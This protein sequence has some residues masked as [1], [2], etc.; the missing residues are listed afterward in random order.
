MPAA[1]TRMFVRSFVR[2]PLGMRRSVG[3]S[4]GD[5]RNRHVAAA[6]AFAASRQAGGQTNGGSGE[7]QH[8]WIGERG[9]GRTDVRWI[10]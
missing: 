8:G 7:R 1:V 10:V 3:R 4:Y 6:A 2:S 9:G 5:P